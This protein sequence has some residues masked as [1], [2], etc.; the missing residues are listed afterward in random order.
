MNGWE[1]ATTIAGLVLL[2]DAIYLV[3]V[4]FWEVSSRA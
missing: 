4:R 3:R 2:V 1:V